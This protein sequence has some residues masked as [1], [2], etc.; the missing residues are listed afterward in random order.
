MLVWSDSPLICLRSFLIASGGIKA[1]EGKSIAILHDTSP[2]RKKKS[3]TSES[4]KSHSLGVISLF[5]GISP[6]NPTLF[7]E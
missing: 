5:K 3:A 7:S 1:R 6:Q 2:K 4:R